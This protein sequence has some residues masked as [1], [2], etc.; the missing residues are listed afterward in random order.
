[1]SDPLDPT[2]PG[3]TPP[4]SDMLKAVQ[5]MNS[6]MTQMSTT[7]K[8]LSD[9]IAAMPK[10]MTQTSDLAKAIKES[11]GEVVKSVEKLSEKMEKVKDTEEKTRTARKDA[12][13]T[14]AETLLTSEELNEEGQ[15][16]LEA[17]EGVLEKG[18]ELKKQHQDNAQFY[19][20][21]TTKSIEHEKSLANQVGLFEQM[22]RA[23]QEM[24]DSLSKNEK[25]GGAYGKAT[26]SIA[27]V[28]FG[29][30]NI[31]ES[32]KGIGGSL[33]ELMPAA[34][35]IGGLVGLMIAGRIEDAKFDAIGQVAA[36]QFDKIGGHTRKF[37][38]EMGTLAREL[39][40]HSMGSADDVAAVAQS[41]ASTGISA[42]E[43]Q[44]HIA[45]FSGE[46]GSNLVVASL[47]ADKALEM[48][49]GTMAKMSGMMAQ[50]FNTSAESAFIHLSNVGAAARKSGL[51]MVTFMQ[52]TMDASSSL[53]LLNANYDQVGSMQL[54][55]VNAMKGQ[56][57]GTQYAGQYAAAGTQQFTSGVAGMS[58][59]VAAVL[60]QRMGYGGNDPMA[61]MYGMLS[62]G[63]LGDMSRGKENKLDPGKI[64]MEMFN[65]SKENTT[66][67]FEQAQFLEKV[68]GIGRQGAEA[69][70]N[71]GGD[72]EKNGGTISKEAA[73]L[74]KDAMRTESEKT[75]SIDTSLKE[76]KDGFMK[77]GSGL[78]TMVV[79][80]LKL[81]VDISAYGFN[82]LIAISPFG[83]AAD[84]K[85]AAQ[86]GNKMDLDLGNMGKGAGGIVAGIK[87]AGHGALRGLDTFGLTNW[88]PDEETPMER[89]GRA[90][91][92][93]ADWIHD[94]PD[95]GG[96]DGVGLIKH[97]A[98][99]IDAGASK[100]ANKKKPNRRKGQKY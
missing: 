43:A 69:V 97:G 44:A 24:N 54:K 92:E 84:A 68:F 63:T 90:G 49:A 71:V 3:G 74:Y 77:I 83:N 41:L 29:K 10:Q 85:R 62:G 47:A 64:A 27:E 76:I 35:G 37:A 17:I 5:E 70:M 93:M 26:A 11:F 75:S 56:G 51:D 20:D 34:G 88:T 57:F 4:S 40:K 58:E 9:A 86:W 32:L 21:Q 59:G 33:A 28:G 15:K 52:Q 13:D 61:A 39:D 96:L 7:S 72:Y 2:G 87:E 82:K 30:K 31:Q 18:I 36:Q 89:A 22:K 50:Q 81:L 99:L 67:P 46:L 66:N 100:L 42:R 14:L 25:F 45:G 53:R 80:A 48:P 98:K 23:A 6:Q 1:M 65:M 12:F 60:G 91:K 79:S 73:A 78:L 38:A 8:Q 55:F 19:A 95:D 94:H 16:Y